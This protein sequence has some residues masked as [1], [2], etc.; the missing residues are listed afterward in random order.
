[1]IPIKYN[2]DFQEERPSPNVAVTAIFSFLFFIFV[3]PVFTDALGFLGI[4]SFSANVYPV[5]LTILTLVLFCLAAR[6]VDEKRCI[7]AFICS[8]ALMC[9]FVA[10][11]SFIYPGSGESGHLN[12]GDT[13][14]GPAIYSWAVDWF[15][16]IGTV[17]VIYVFHEK[18]AWELIWGFFFASGIYLMLNMAFI[19]IQGFGINPIKTLPFGYMN[20]TFRIAIP[21]FVCAFAI[22]VRYKRGYCLLPVFVYLVC[23]LQILIAYSATSFCAFIVMGI[24]ALVSLKKRTRKFLNS[25]TYSISYIV[26][27]FSVVVLRVQ[28]LMGPVISVILRKDVTFTGRTILWDQAFQKLFGW[29][30]FTGYGNDYYWRILEWK[31]ALQKH[32]H[33]EVLNMLMLGGI[34]AFASMATMVVVAIRRLYKQRFQDIANVFAIGLAGFLV[35]AIAEIGLSPGLMFVLAGSYYLVPKIVGDAESYA[36]SME[37]PI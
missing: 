25:L 22:S 4:H 11:T 9:L 19:C 26:V 3:K 28:N 14:F 31:G 12:N 15:P 35:I 30:F 29:H 17:C 34:F 24:L 10:I 37:L 1:M 27:T 18:F 36:E 5:L 16:L 33:N 7:D 23:F 13:V 2:P 21:C 32:A 20:V 6:V 8:F